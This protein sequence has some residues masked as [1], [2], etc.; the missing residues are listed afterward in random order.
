MQTGM[1]NRIKIARNKIE[2]CRARPEKRSARRE[3]GRT[4]IA[5]ARGQ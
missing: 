3:I 1:R 4:G 5:R 2:H